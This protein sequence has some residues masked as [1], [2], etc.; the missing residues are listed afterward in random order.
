MYPLRKLQQAK[1]KDF[2]MINGCEFRGQ[3]LNF[4]SHDI[5][6]D[7]NVFTI[8]VG[9]NGVGKSLLLQ[10]LVC[11]FV[12]LQERVRERALFSNNDNFENFS[13]SLNFSNYPSRIIAS[14]TSPFDKFPLDRKRDFDS[15][16]QYLGLKGL[17]SFNLSLGFIGR[18]IG[19]LI[20]ALEKNSGHLT[21]V[22]RVFEY[23]DY[24]PYMK[25]RMVLD[26]QPHKI[27]EILS[28]ED[29]V[30]ALVDQMARRGNLSFVVEGSRKSKLTISQLHSVLE[31]LSYFI[32][33]KEKPRIDIVIN[34]RGV[35][36]ADTG[37]SINRVF[38]ILMDT[39]LLKIRDV[40]LQKTGV[41]YDIQISDA[42]S[43]EQCVLMALLGIASQIEDHALICIDEPEICLHPEWQ[44]KYIELLMESF[45]SF[46]HCHFVIATHSPQI[47]S[48]LAS[49]NCFVLD[50]QKGETYAAYE[51]NKKS[52]DFQLANVF[53]APGFKNEYLSREIVSALGVLGSGGELSVE[54]LETLYD[55]IELKSILDPEDPVHRLI[56]LLSDALEGH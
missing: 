11:S 22:L 18:T 32:A 48:N 20:N 52:A 4:H 44:E 56:G 47:V 42:S 49:H 38:G 26:L 34:W 3:Y 1:L 43:G 45:S 12:P 16:Y 50:M 46:K 8:V 40:S 55:I 53:G 41:D 29:P 39:G 51:V 19:A 17:P 54:R 31:A 9:K 36:D 35:I 5:Y 2:R 10:Q 14:S 28:S 15:V 30:D 21:A 6:D 27:R 37:S 13:S 23:L 33:T 7:S 25:A 24:V